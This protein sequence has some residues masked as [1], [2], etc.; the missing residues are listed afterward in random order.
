[1]TKTD[2]KMPFEKQKQTKK[3][4]KSKNKTKNKTKTKLKQKTNKTKQ[5]KTKKKQNKTNKYHMI[6]YEYDRIDVVSSI[7]KP[8][9]TVLGSIIQVCYTFSKEKNA[10]D[11][12]CT[13]PPA[14]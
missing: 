13:M 14:L 5:N 6:L 7:H 11:F 12:K 4:N 3:K 9:D 8:L 10:G 2:T 1:M